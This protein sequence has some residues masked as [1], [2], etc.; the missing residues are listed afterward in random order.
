MIAGAF[1]KQFGG[2]QGMRVFRAPGRVNLIGEHTDYNFGFVLPIALDLACFIAAADSDDGY[3]RVYSEEKRQLR[4][5]PVADLAQLAPARDWTD[6][7]IGVA[8]E[9]I[10]AGYPI[11]PKRLFIRSSVPEGSDLSSSAALEVS[12]ALALLGGREIAPLNLAELCQ[13]AET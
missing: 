8:Q 10:R 7:L 2:S 12:A 11:H 4:A 1:Q 9:L 13:R 5:W 6:Y 3:L